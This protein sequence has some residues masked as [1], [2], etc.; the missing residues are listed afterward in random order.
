MI[1]SPMML[2]RLVCGLLI[3]GAPQQGGVPSE[4]PQGKQAAIRGRV[5]DKVTGAPIARAVVIVTRMR[6]NQAIQALT[7]A[8][9]RFEFVKLAPDAYDV[10]ATAGEFS[11]TYV[12]HGRGAAPPVSL[13]PGETREVSIALAPAR[14]ISGRVVDDSGLPLTGVRIRLRDRS[15]GVEHHGFR[16][17]ATDDLGAFRAFGVAAGTY[18]VCAETHLA[19]RFDRPHQKREPRFVTT[20]YPSATEEADAEPV[21]LGDAG[22]EGVE[23]RM[24]RRPAYMVSGVVLDATGNRAG[25]VNLDVLRIL[26]RGSSGTGRPIRGGDFTVSNLTPGKYVLTAQSGGPEHP[27]AGSERQMA[28]QA[29]E[30]TSADVEGLVLMMKKGARVRGIL[31][32]EDGLPADLR[33]ERLNVLLHPGITGGAG[34]PAPAAVTPDLRF[35]AEDL[36]GRLLITVSGLPA[37]AVVRSVRYPGGEILD[38]PTEFEEDPRAIIEVLI[39]SRSAELSG[40]VLDE[41]G[42]PYEDARIYCF[43]ADPGRWEGY[44]S[45]EGFSGKDGVF[46]VRDLA[47]GEYLV[48]AISVDG[49]KALI[50]GDAHDKELRARLSRIAERV[51]LLDNDRRTLDLRVTPIPQEWKR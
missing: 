24:Q 41:R 34:P 25:A 8:E 49:Q 14:A 37:G 39:T 5:V 38:R 47:P 40:R 11:A 28:F 46:R 3:A 44:M 4:L 18:I 42:R 29:I 36:F 31:T 48:A 35:E 9:G 22:I 12:R 2:T 7:D 20:C 33:T 26:G 45:G 13:R 1:L 23:I 17:G 15:T 50:A 10:S 16:Q 27:A 43:P 32:F 6:A 21:V 19:I 30:V 51:T